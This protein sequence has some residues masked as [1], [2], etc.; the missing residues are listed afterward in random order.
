MPIFNSVYKA[1]DGWKPWANTLLYLPLEW[2]A[3]DTSWNWHNGI[4]DW[5][6]SYTTL[7]SWLKVAS[8]SSSWYIKNTSFWTMAWDRTVLL[9]A[10]F[11]SQNWSYQ[12]LFRQLKAYSNNN[13][14]AIILVGENPTTKANFSVYWVES[15]QIDC[16]WTRNLI[17]VTVTS[18][19]SM[20]FYKNWVQ[21]TS[22]T[23]FTYNWY[24]W[25]QIWWPFNNG[26]PYLTG[27]VSRVIVENKIRTEQEIAD[28]YD[29][30]KANYGL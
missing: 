27:N 12:P 2:D 9:W 21:Q 24:T 1:I 23:W 15:S 25:Y 26:R 14:W 22:W 30:T 3:N 6:A 16:W 7:S 18:S 28:Y 5:T 29:K 10:K 11:P 19:W 13:M 8:L 20:I 17:A 4:W